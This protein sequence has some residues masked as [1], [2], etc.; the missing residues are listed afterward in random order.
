MLRIYRGSEPGG[1]GEWSPEEDVFAFGPEHAWLA[2]AVGV[3]LY[4][5]GPVVARGTIEDGYLRDATTGFGAD[6]GDGMETYLALHHACWVRMGSPETRAG[7][8]T[9]Y[10][11]HG[12]A[13][14]A[15][16]HGQL[17]DLAG[18]RDD[19][20]GWALVDPRGDSD[21]AR[22]SDARIERLYQAERG[23][24]PASA[25][26][27]TTVAEV[28]A[29]DGEWGVYVLRDD[30]HRPVGLA[31]YRKNVRLGLDV[32]G[33][34]TR[35]WVTKPY[36]EGPRGLPD[37]AGRAALEDL[38]VRLKAAVEKDGEAILIMV[39]IDQGTAE[40]IIHA[41][42]EEPTCTLVETFPGVDEGLESSYSAEEDPE[43]TM[44]FE[45]VAPSR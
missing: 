34:P 10:D 31:R 25:R 7:L 1:G 16:Y 23:G 45:K 44:Y 15:P 41:R 43:W 42:K 22:R 14:I 30:A 2:D 3:R 4:G 20:K 37:P 5:D 24:R 35:I 19:G 40:F 33:Y 12:W 18:L 13:L 6:V 27:A 36:A 29:A 32:S 17:F 38:E 9:A 21:E 8:V 26:K 11:S 39:M 28:L